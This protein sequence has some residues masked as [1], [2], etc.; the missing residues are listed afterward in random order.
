M[1]VLFQCIPMN[2]TN[3]PSIA[4]ISGNR[5]VNDIFNGKLVE[6]MLASIDRPCLSSHCIHV[7]GVYGVY[8]I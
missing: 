8:R 6:P 3:Y 2:H 4:T 5:P 7:N 1:T